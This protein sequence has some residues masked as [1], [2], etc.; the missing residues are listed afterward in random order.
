MIIRLDSSMTRR[1]YTLWRL[2]RP[3]HLT[4]PAS[5]SRSVRN[6]KRLLK[7]RDQRRDV[8]REV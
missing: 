2:P 6:Q 1:L 3:K 8:A 5:A 7:L 4:N